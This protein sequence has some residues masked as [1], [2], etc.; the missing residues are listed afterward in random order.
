MLR[1]FLV[2]HLIFFVPCWFLRFFFSETFFFFRK[3][4]LVLACVVQCQWLSI[5]Y[6]KINNVDK[7]TCIFS[8][9]LS[10]NNDK[11]KGIKN[12]KWCD[13]FGSERREGS[14]YLCLDLEKRFY[15]CWNTNFTRSIPRSCSVWF[16][17]HTHTHIQ[18]ERREKIF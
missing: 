7:P 15:D 17:A 2:S 11:H 5:S 1:F 4:R 3:K 9:R 14:I 10:L 8:L 16:S 6:W 18:E 12:G 13:G